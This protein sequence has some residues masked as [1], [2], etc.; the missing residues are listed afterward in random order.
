MIRTLLMIF[1]IF[2]ASSTLAEGQSKINLDYDFQRPGGDYTNFFT[3]NARECA[4]KCERSNSCQAFDFHSSDKSCWLKNI[5][6]P[7]R[8]YPGVISGAKRP[9]HSGGGYAGSSGRTEN[10]TPAHIHLDYDTQRP[11]GDYTRFQSRGAQECAQQCAKEPQCVAFDYTT[12][13]SFCYLKSWRPPSRYYSGIVSGVK[14]NYNSQVKTVQERLIQQN[15]NPGPADGLMGKKTR[16][17]LKNY[18][19]NNHLLVT[20]RIDDATLISLGLL[21]PPPPRPAPEAQVQEKPKRNAIEPQTVSADSQNIAASG[22]E[23][24]MYVKSAGV[25]Y[26]QS[27]DDIYADILAKIPAGTILQVLS[28]SG[29]WY[30]VSYQNQVGYILAESVKK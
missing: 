21:Q 14:R 22:N 25:T 9:G 18:Q 29:E 6:Y 3:A 23:F 28:E 17:A 2:L 1:F 4:Q 11:G 12:S 10:A 26:L 7:G 15:Y 27:T 16:V 30:K 19:I 5:A 13:D 8:R 20:G 24:A